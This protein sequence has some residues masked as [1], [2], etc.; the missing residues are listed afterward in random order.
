MQNYTFAKMP[1][2]YILILI[3]SMKGIISFSLGLALSTNQILISESERTVTVINSSNILKWAVT[4]LK[5]F[6]F[7]RCTET[8]LGSEDECMQLGS[9]QVSNTVIYLGYDR[10][11]RNNKK[12]TVVTTWSRG[13]TINGESM[14]AEDEMEKNNQVYT[15]VLGGKVGLSQN[16]LSS[17]R[18]LQQE[19][20]G[21]IAEKREKVVALL[22]DSNNV[23]GN[24]EHDVVLALDP[25]PN[26]NY[27]HLI[28][29]FYIDFNVESG[30]CR[31]K[32]Q[33]YISGK[34]L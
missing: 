4:G 21:T 23:K 26:A 34:I 20:V 19:S 32:H 27:G 22:P 31:D 18:R 14:D 2:F 16:T 28:G 10:N 25:Y 17:H 29:L 6:E 13:N 11:W 24:G 15:Y 5:F 30:N 1:I 3:F 33:I 8:G 9:V 7:H 12:K